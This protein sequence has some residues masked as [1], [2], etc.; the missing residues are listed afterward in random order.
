MKPNKDLILITG[1]TGYV[2][3]RLLS[4]LEE[5]NFNMRCMVRNPDY[6]KDKVLPT[7]E[8]IA[9]D[10]L[11]IGSLMK[12]MNGVKTAYFL[13]HAMGSKK[14][15]VQLEYDI[16]KNFAI[17]AQKA[18]VE[19]I[20]YLG[21]L[22]PSKEKLSAHLESR[23]KV[24]EILRES[25]IQVFE[26]RASIIIGSGSLSYEMIRSLVDKLPIMVTPRW[27]R[28]KAQPIFIEDVIDYL[29]AAI[30]IPIDESEVFEIGG[31]NIVT[32]EQ[33][34]QE[35]AKQRDLKRFMIPVPALSPRLSSW[36]LNLV[37]PIYARI[38]RKLIDSIKHPTVVENPLASQVFD[39]QPLSVKE[40]IQKTIDNEGRDW[41][42]SRW[43]DAIG[44][45]GPPKPLNLETLNKCITDD[46]KI[47]VKTSIEKAFKPIRTIG[48]K[49]GWY[50]GNTLWRI[51]GFLDSWFGGVGLRRGRRDPEH[52]RVGE[53]LDFWRVEEYIPEKKLKLFA[54][55]RLPGK[56]WLEFE[57]T[58]K[59]DDQCEIRQTAIYYPKG[60][61][62]QLYWYLLYPFHVLIFQGMLNTIAQKALGKQ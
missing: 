24:G 5:N 32:Y 15:F 20:I 36:W 60:L 4:A 38:G 57:V 9:G 16:A 27:V 28:V 41:I 35:Y 1:A 53:A 59:K 34:M 40:A 8:V 37:T 46:R 55:M 31:K 25:G 56:A 52:L 19:K 29:I 33:L 44:S 10:G 2:G 21:G 42:N 17:A 43:S 12:A 22:V 50:C 3:G 61:G 11:D 26:F 30:N 51:R 48:G 14:D 62:G 13:I 23:L 58:E 54:E 45:V 47:I 49:N 7:T 6:M 39:I 18:G